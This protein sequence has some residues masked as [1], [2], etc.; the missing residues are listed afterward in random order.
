MNRSLSPYRVLDHDALHEENERLKRQIR[1][2]TGEDFGIQPFPSGLDPDAPWDEHRVPC[3]FCTTSHAGHFWCEKYNALQHT[4]VP[5]PSICIG[6][7]HGLF[8]LSRCR[9]VVPHRHRHCTN[10]KKTWLEHARPA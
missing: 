9:V 1:V 8:F 4:Y 10:C 5:D 7:R 6:R 2:L 3:P